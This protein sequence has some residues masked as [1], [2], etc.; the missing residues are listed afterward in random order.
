MVPWWDSAGLLK[1]S[2]SEVVL[3]V[4]VREAARATGA[5]PTVS[6]AQRRAVEGLTV[7]ETLEHLL[8]HGVGCEDAAPSLLA[9][10]EWREVGRRDLQDL[11]RGAHLLLEAAGR[12]TDCDIEEVG[13]LLAE[14][15][16]GRGEPPS[17]LWAVTVTF[18]P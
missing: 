2:S 13:E 18:E 7:P 10:V 16:R 15:S 8:K 4:L 9:R 11:E 3:G 6:A 14:S 17:K 12:A 1:G 5:A